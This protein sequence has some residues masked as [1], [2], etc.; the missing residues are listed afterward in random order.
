MKL[1]FSFMLLA[2]TL[3]VDIPQAQA[4]SFCPDKNQCYYDKP[5]SCPV[6]Q[7]TLFE[8]GCGWECCFTSGSQSE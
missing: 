7:T 4:V 6:G 2:T 1:L 5:T 8:K 3:M